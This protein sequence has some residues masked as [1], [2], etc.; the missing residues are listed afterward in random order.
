MFSSYLLQACSF[1]M[2]NSKGMAPEVFSGREE[3]VEAEGQVEVVEK[4]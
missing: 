4:V 2:R 3:L 1:L